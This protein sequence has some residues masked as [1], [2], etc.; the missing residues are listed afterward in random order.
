M[1]R[2]TQALIG[3][4]LVA[5]GV[6]AWALSLAEGEASVRRVEDVVAEPARYASGEHVLLGVPQPPLV[7]VVGDEGK[8]LVENPDW[9]DHTS[10]TVRW[11]DDDGAVWYSTRSV[12]VTIQGD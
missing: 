6:G 11:T 1:N 12:N 9:S 7:P 5:L 10:H 3:L 8:T 4:S 2:R